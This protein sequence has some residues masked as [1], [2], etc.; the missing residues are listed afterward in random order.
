MLEMSSER[1]KTH[2]PIGANPVAQETMARILVVDDERYVR[3]VL[4]KLLSSEGFQSDTA[5]DV[6]EAMQKLAESEYEMVVCR[7]KANAAG[8]AYGNRQSGGNLK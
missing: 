2:L 5:E 4:T 1:L 7:Q 3:A 8:L 6:Q